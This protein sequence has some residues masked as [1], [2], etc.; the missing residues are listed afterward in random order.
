[1][2]KTI[3]IMK[4]DITKQ[5]V[6]CIVSPGRKDVYDVHGIAAKIWEIAGRKIKFEIPSGKSISYGDAYTTTG[7]DLPASFIIHTACLCYDPSTSVSE[8]Y[9]SESWSSCMYEACD[10]GANEIAFPAIGT[11]GFQFP[12]DIA[13]KI[14]ISVLSTFIE[15]SFAKDMTVAIVCDADTNTYPA[16][17][18]QLEELFIKIREKDGF[19]VDFYSDTQQTVLTT[20]DI[21]EHED[22][23]IVDDIDFT[24]DCLDDDLCNNIVDN[25]DLDEDIEEHDCKEETMPIIESSEAKY[26]S[27]HTR[28][29][30]FEYEFD[31]N[32]IDKTLHEIQDLMDCMEED[33]EMSIIKAALNLGIHIKNTHCRMIPI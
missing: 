14:A 15:D 12:V 16:Y 20:I 29:Y 6:D 1:M 9:L 30:R 5:A 31:Y 8:D 33:I 4:G 27:N 26:H 19:I 21:R 7:C 18:K 2:S 13:S 25:K 28:R 11:G 24:D 32:G 22:S 17:R 23:N 3:K 10:L